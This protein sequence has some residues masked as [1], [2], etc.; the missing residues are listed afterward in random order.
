MLRENKLGDIN[1]DNIP[2][3]ISIR[4]IYFFRPFLLHK[5]VIMRKEKGG[6]WG[7]GGGVGLFIGK[8]TS[9]N[10]FKEP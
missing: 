1:G 7:V 8:C 9:Q 3:P 6:G 4:R 2:R 10:P 5:S